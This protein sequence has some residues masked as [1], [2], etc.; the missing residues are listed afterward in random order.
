M[1]TIKFAFICVLRQGK[2]QGYTKPLFFDL[3]GLIR[4]FKRRLKTTSG[5]YVLNQVLYYLYTISP[6]RP[7]KIVL[8]GGLNVG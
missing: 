2:F 6:T 3:P 4:K 5:K 7:Y 8:K 1:S